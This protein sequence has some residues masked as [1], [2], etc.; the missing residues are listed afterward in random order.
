MERARERIK[1]VGSKGLGSTHPCAHEAS[2]LCLPRVVCCEW[3]RAGGGGEE[4]QQGARGSRHLQH[5]GMQL[6]SGRGGGGRSRRHRQPRFKI[7][8]QLPVEASGIL[9]WTEVLGR[10]P[11]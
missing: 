10:I 9:L 7:F 8:P 3:G 2:A 5:I 11:K 6:H 4:E 1:D